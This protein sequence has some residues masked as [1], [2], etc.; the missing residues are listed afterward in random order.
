MK[1][2]ADILK[3]FTKYK[4]TNLISSSVSC[5]STRNKPTG[6]THCG[7]C[8]QCIERRFA[9]FAEGLDD[10]ALESYESNFIDHIPNN[11][12]KQRLYNTLYFAAMPEIQNKND[13]LEKYFNEIDDIIDYMPGNN[14]ETKV[15]EL[16]MFICRNNS[17]IL[18]AA[19]KMQDRYEN[20]LQEVPHN[21]LLEM[22]AQREYLRSP[23][24]NRVYEINN[25]LL[26]AIP[27]MF[28][29]EKPKNE[30]A[31]NDR[32]QTML[33]TYGKFEREYPILQFG[34]TSYKAD[35]SQDYLII[36]SKYIRGST[37]PSTASS[38]IASDI[39]LIPTDYGIL[40][41]V[42]DP[43]RKISSDDIFINSFEEKRKNCFVRIFR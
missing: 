34:I 31:F 37:S 5:S 2:K 16:Y 3:I 1:T 32:I 28:Q 42:Y 12:T 33:S 38:G 20:L 30:N 13:F 21:S 26:K 23:I 27:L 17:T 25:A 29:R 43:E 10:S 18:A 35:H 4:E 15:E 40:F 14:P 6:Y 19:K 36:E 22:L 41:V 39:T 11:E 7:C 9:I 8:S 24:F